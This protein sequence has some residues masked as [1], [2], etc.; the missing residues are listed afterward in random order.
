MSA[1]VV[2]RVILPDGG[3][4]YISDD[5]QG[6]KRAAEIYTKYGNCKLEACY[7][8]SGKSLDELEPFW[9][10]TIKEQYS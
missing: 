1:S 7:K 10:G 2:N 8:D 4:M 9:S 6:D 3:K 5:A